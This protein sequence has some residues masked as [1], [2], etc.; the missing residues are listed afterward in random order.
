VF[1]AFLPPIVNTLTE[2]TSIAL[3]QQIQQRAIAIPL[4]DSPIQTTYVHQGTQHPP[5]LLIHGFDSS[6]MEYRRLMPLLAPHYETWA[7]DLLTFGFTDRPVGLQFSAAEI[8]Q[9]L[10]HSWQ[11]LINSP[12]VLVGAS[13]GGAAAIDFALTYPDAVEKLIL[14]DSAGGAK[15]PNMG[16]F[17]VP[18][19]GFLAAEF[20]R[21]PRV[22]RS[23]SRSAYFD[24]RFAT[25]DAAC[26]AALHLE[27]PL[28][29]PSMVAFTRS[30][31]Y[32]T[33]RWEQIAQVQQPTLVLWGRNDQIIGTKDAPVFER[34]IPGCK[35]VWIENCGHVPHL[36]KPQEPADHILRYLS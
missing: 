34:T 1:P 7:I 16:N 17:L 25:E 15:G 4:L 10:Y 8:K 14:L 13:M 11:T 3:A 9:H 21:N 2:E 6:V 20:L 36:E 28:W 32:N 30:G 22:R 24:K 23:I 33:L 5:I 18:P 35:L 27:H 29:N 19:L 31:G 26:C 12:V